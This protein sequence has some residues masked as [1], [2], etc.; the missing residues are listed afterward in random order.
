MLALITA[1]IL[2]NFISLNF[3][4]FYIGRYIIF[5]GYI[6]YFDLAFVKEILKN[7][8]CTNNSNNT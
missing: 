3:I 8:Q 7:H 6:A 5:E 1:K 4:L 2:I